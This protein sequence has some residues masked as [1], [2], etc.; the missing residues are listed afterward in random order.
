MNTSIFDMPGMVNTTEKTANPQTNIKVTYVSLG[1]VLNPTVS[2]RQ[3]DFIF[4]GF[5][6][7][8]CGYYPKN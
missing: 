4:A 8:V 2:G 5:V 1:I 3:L 6:S 7:F